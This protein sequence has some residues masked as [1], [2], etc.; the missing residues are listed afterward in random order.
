MSKDRDW[1]IAEKNQRLK[2]EVRRKGGAIVIQYSQ[3]EQKAISANLPLSGIKL[4]I[5]FDIWK[6]SRGCKWDIFFPILVP[7]SVNMDET[8]FRKA[9]ANG[10]FY[11]ISYPNLQIA[12]QEGGTWMAPLALIR[13]VSFAL[14][15]NGHWSI[16]DVESELAR[17][18]NGNEREKYAA[19]RLKDLLSVTGLGY[20]A[21]D[22]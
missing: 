12:P 3:T 11:E 2:D 1:R 16:G 18:S 22:F 9:L 6:I 21:I 5:I 17:L 7:L 10:R 19:A 8:E 14:L 20:L 13:L 4:Q 15:E